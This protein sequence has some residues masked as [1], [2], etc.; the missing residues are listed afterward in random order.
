MM[1]LHPQAQTICDAMNAVEGPEWTDDTLTE[2]RT[3]FGMLLIGES[4]L[5]WL[6]LWAIG[7][8]FGD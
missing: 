4:I 2:Q 6:A 1:P 5:R 7:Q 3:G 8:L